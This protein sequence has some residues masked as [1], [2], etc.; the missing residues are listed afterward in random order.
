[1]KLIISDRSYMER[2]LEFSAVQVH[3][4]YMLI[5]ASSLK[6]S[7]YYKAAVLA[8]IFYL[9]YYLSDVLL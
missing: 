9:R 7:A 2:S 8:N 5:I 3:S 1:M 6:K 4:G